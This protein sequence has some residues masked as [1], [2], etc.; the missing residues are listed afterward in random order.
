M[1]ELGRELGRMLRESFESL[2]KPAR[3]TPK[4]YTSRSA[5][6]KEAHEI[7][8]VCPVCRRTIVKPENKYRC[9][10]CNAEMY[11]RAKMANYIAGRRIVDVLLGAPYS[12]FS[13]DEADEIED[14]AEIYILLDDG[15]VLCVWHAYREGGGLERIRNPREELISSD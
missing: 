15:T 11:P 3:S 9:P 1:S 4:T 2:R 8:Y 12:Y 13:K 7:T 5:S 14:G 10:V 6:K